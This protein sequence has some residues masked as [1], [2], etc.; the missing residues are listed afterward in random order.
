M[1]LLI[2]SNCGHFSVR[3]YEYTIALNLLSIV[4]TLIISVLIR[5]S[6]KRRLPP[7]QR[8]YQLAQVV[9]ALLCCLHSGTQPEEGSSDG[10]SVSN[11]GG[12]SYKGDW[13]LVF[14]AVHVV[15]M[16]LVIVVYL[17]GIAAIYC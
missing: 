10:V 12:K 15:L 9:N 7:S 3:F 6:E 16:L 1:I 8:L 5:H 14:G 4:C 2:K 13:E 17:I 11:A